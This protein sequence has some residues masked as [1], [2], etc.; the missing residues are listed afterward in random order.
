MPRPVV[1]ICAAVEQA[2]FGH[3]DEF[4]VLI[5]RA[6]ADSIQ[7][8]GGIAIL[9][10]PVGEGLVASGWSVDDDLVEAIEVPGDGFALGVLWHP[11]VD[12]DDRVIRAFVQ[13]ASR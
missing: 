5:Q 11:E 7:A 12:P 3:W 1:G 9:M 10:A 4:A 2:K 13:T 6:Y 8:A